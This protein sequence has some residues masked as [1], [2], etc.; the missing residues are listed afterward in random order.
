MMLPVA[1]LLLQ[2]SAT[3]VN[4][5]LAVSRA[6]TGPP[7]LVDKLVDKYVKAVGNRAGSSG[8]ADPA[9]T[10][11]APESGASSNL[12]PASEPADLRALAV[13]VPLP[14][15]ASLSESVLRDRSEKARRREWVAFAIA[16]HSAA[17]F[18][19]WSTRRALSTGDAQ[20]SNPML[21]PFAGNPSI[22]AAIQVGPV[23]FDYVARRMMSSQYGWARRTWWVLQA[24]STATSLASGAH[25]LTVH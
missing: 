19:A 14:P 13:A 25:N 11:S 24:V 22:Y 23:L 20:E 21:R 6:E 5:G 3:P 1:V 4:P 16:Q 2:I 12:S 9:A 8:G 18:D 10:P 17:T 7:I 15:R